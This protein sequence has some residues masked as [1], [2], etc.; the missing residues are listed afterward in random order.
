MVGR[1]RLGPSRGP[2][3]L[4]SR[5]RLR[6][7]QFATRLSGRMG[8]AGAVLAG[9]GAIGARR[10]GA[11]TAALVRAGGTAKAVGACP[12]RALE[13]LPGAATAATLEDR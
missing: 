7:I 10:A 4:S 11:G 13:N 2:V 1:M 3:I 12:A 5:A 8:Q 6:Q 9:L